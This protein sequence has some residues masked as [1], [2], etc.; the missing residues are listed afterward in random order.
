MIIGVH[1]SMQHGFTNSYWIFMLMLTTLIL[2]QLQKNK[3]SESENS[4]IKSPD[5]IN[6]VSTNTLNVPAKK[7]RKRSR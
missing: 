7:K 5:Q 6:P 2:Y 4:A 3:R 1:Q